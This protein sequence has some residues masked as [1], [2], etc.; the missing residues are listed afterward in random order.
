MN[1]GRH[2][3]LVLFGWLP[4]RLAFAADAISVVDK[5]PV[6]WVAITMF[7]VFV[8]ITLWITQWAAKKTRSSVDFYTAGGTVTGFQNGLAIAGDYVSAASFLGITS[9]VMANGYD[10]MLYAIGFLVGWP[11]LTFLIAERLRNL[12]KYT[13]ADVVAYRFAATS[14]RLFASVSTLVV[15][16]CYLIAQMVG[17]GALIRL[18]FGLDY[19][20]A[21]VLVGGLMMV[22]VLFGGMA[23][24][25]WV[26]IIKAVLLLIGATFMAFMIMRRFGF[27]FEGL[28]ASAV[29]VKT[30]IAMAGGKSGEEAKA[31]GLSIMAPGSFIK[32]PISAISLSIA[33]VFGTAGLPHILMRFFTVPD[34]RQARHSVLWAITWIGY[35]YIL[36][37][38]IGFGAIVLVLAN[39]QYADIASGT[40]RGGQG[41]ANM[42]AVLVAKVVGGNVFMGFVSAVAFATILAVVAG[43]AL[44]GASAVSHDV[45]AMVI[46]QGK[47]SSDTELLVSRVTTAV[48]GV[49]AVLLGIVF[50]KQNVAFMV[51][52][53]FAIAASAN[54]PVL[55]LSLFWKNCTTRGAVIGGFLGLI[56]SLVLTV[57]S[58]SVWVDT[59]GHS[60]DSVR[61][62]YT[63]PALFSMT[64]GFVGIWL[65]SVLDRSG[66]AAKERVAFKA[67]QVRA[68][69]G[70]G[71]SK[72]S[73]N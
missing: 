63:S 43:L 6:N 35:C 13:F 65:F 60:V 59:L 33:L 58:P 55:V 24:T 18:L 31:L 70:L 28:F 73:P 71:A 48:L 42:A 34:A 51:S 3:L 27:N 56:S 5:Q 50:Q 32:D 44:S 7:A 69:T 21:M 16:L 47:P 23:A 11:I 39:P 22:Y 9:A 40:I 62:P 30:Q 67:Q 68:E 66:R 57:L 17:A 49:V 52:L 8:L 45:Y 20:V 26:Q 54:F 41:A 53:A 61:F 15:V 72:M 38:I 25:T 36:M 2:L 64:I 4:V 19:W 46:K 37:F 10:G 29:E 1:I 12:G 14:V